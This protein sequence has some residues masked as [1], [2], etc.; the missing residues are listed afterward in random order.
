MSKKLYLAG[1]LFSEADRNQRLLEAKQLRERFS[2]LDVFNPIEQP[3][4]TDKSSLPTPQTIYD[5]DA[6]RVM[7]ADIFLADI[8]QYDPGV[9]VELGLVLTRKDC[10]IVCVDSDIRLPDA[11]RYEIPTYG[12]N[13][14]VLGGILKHGFL[15][16]DFASAMD[17]IERK[18]KK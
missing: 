18:I 13:H 4:N 5:G 17:L 2:F 3:F 8:T 12:L 16:R 15:V 6:Q 14:F 11:N 1:P 7:D 10:L 9:M